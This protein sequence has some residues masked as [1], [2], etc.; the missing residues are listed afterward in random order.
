MGSR[1]L[2]REYPLGIGDAVGKEHG[3][4]HCQIGEDDRYGGFI[5]VQGGGLL[6][7]VF[8][9]LV[10]AALEPDTGAGPGEALRWRMAQDVAGQ[11]V[12]LADALAASGNYFGVLGVKPRIGRLF[13]PTDDRPTAPPVAVISSRYWQSRFGGDP[14]IAGRV[15][16]VNDVPVT[17]VGVTP[18]EF[19]G[20]Q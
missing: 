20:V 11:V 19:T 17:I 16:K 2:L 10:G 6:V 18:A 14:S 13:T 7:P 12:A 8:F 15:I 9:V 4:P 1:K 5:R 3:I